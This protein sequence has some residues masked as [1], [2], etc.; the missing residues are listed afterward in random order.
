MTKWEYCIH[1]SFLPDEFRFPKAQ[2]LLDKYGNEGWEMVA[3][4]E[5]RGNHYYFF[6][7]MKANEVLA[8]TQ[9]EEDGDRLM[10]EAA[11][12]IERLRARLITAAASDAQ[13]RWPESIGFSPRKS[14]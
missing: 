2:E 11:D 3:L 5:I 1:A 13:K 12:T 7:R 4:S 8:Q 14:C 10:R 9:T 6:K